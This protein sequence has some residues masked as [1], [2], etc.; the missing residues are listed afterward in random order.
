MAHEH[1]LP[2]RPEEITPLDAILITHDHPDHIDLDA[3][4]MLPD[5]ATCIVA[6]NELAQKA[7]NAG[8]KE[9]HVLA[10]WETFSLR[11]VKVTAVPALHDIYEIGFV[12][13]GPKTT[14]DPTSVYFAGD[15]KLH[16]ALP[17]VRE[18]FAPQASI[19][20]V[21]GTRIRGGDLHV[22]RPEHA[23]EAARILGSRVVMPSH[24]EGV[25]YD[26]LAK[27]VISDN[28]DGSGLI[29]RD[30]MKAALPTIRCELPMPGELVLI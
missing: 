15:T 24:A 27:Y 3:L 16:P 12:L 20:P 18:R 25:L 8:R 11:D 1:P 5:N 23:V 13:Q 30:L 10:P 9:T 28:I 29:F 21:D 2:A 26:P 19:L 14:G 22:M 7:K 4:A 17:E 6:T